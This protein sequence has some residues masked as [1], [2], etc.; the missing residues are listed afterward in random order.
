M[1]VRVDR[2]G[3]TRI[4]REAGRSITVCLEP[5]RDEFMAHFIAQLS[6]K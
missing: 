4:D 2:D 3:Y 6:A 5:K 1:P